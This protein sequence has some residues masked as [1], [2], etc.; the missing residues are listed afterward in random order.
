MD[1]SNEEEEPLEVLFCNSKSVSLFG[2][3]F[4]E[5][6]E[7]QEDLLHKK[8]ELEKLR[9]AN[10]KRSYENQEPSQT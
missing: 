6:P 3:D 1:E 5:Q 8:D 2:L 10:I 4:S 9:F 7:S